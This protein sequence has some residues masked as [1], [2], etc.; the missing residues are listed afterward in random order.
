MFSP[1]VTAPSI[2][3]RHSVSMGSTGSFGLDGVVEAMGLLPICQMSVKHSHSYS[4]IGWIIKY[5][6]ADNQGVRLNRSRREVELSDGSPN[7]AA[8]HFC[9]MDFSR[10]LTDVMVRS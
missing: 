1:N 7:T 8:S 4:T 10:K 2:L 3:P 6:D 9:S 5:K